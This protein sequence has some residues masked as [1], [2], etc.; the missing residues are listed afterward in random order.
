MRRREYRIAVRR[1]DEG[2]G[3]S[4]FMHERVQRRR[5]AARSKP[6]K[7]EFPLARW[8]ACAVLVAGGIG[9][10]PLISMAAQRKADGRPV[11]HALRR[12]QPRADGLPAELQALLGDD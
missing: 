11:R 12:P 4:R 1:E 6:P 5:H 8:T 10:T 9:I 7:N 3:G 2:R